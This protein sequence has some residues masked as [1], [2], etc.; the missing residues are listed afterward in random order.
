MTTGPEAKT[1]NI[2]VTFEN[3]LE[4]RVIATALS[5]GIM[6]DLAAEDFQDETYALWWE[7][8]C[9]YADMHDL[10]YVLL[11]EYVLQKTGEDH[12]EYL[13]ALA[14]HAFPEP[15]QIGAYVDQLRSREDKQRITRTHS[16][17]TADSRNA[18]DAAT[19]QDEAI[20][21]LKAVSVR[22]RMEYLTIEQAVR[23]STEE[24]ARL[25]EAK[26]MPGITTGFPTLD[27]KTGGWQKSDLALIAARPAVGKTALMCNFALA[28][29]CRIG[30]VSTEQP[31]VQ[32]VNRLTAISGNI[33]AW[34]FRNPS[35]FS[36]DEWERLTP[37]TAGL[38]V[39]PSCRGTG[40]WKKIWRGILQIGFVRSPN[41]TNST[42]S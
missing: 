13:R 42:S 26:G 40:C 10:D 27:D 39:V 17:L 16:E 4:T 24:L 1:V 9:A 11:G 25:Y 3:L 34:K 31:A 5:T 35:K 20:A 6:P 14:K 38:T 19:V 7:V 32:I 28:A 36:P 33:Q 15:D 41:G 30:I 22:K 29:D 21:A 2:N 12:R 18:D 23:K 8:M 37:A